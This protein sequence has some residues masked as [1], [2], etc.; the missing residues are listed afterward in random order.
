VFESRV[1]RKV[2][3][4]ERDKMTGDW[5][6]LHNEDLHNLYFSKV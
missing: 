1:L 3:G 2:F 6:D 4:P 5:G